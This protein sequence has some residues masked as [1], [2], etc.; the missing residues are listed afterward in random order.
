M[1]FPISK[2]AKIL[3]YLLF[4]LALSSGI[5]AYSRESEDTDTQLISNPLRIHY[6]GTVEGGN[7][8]PWDG[9]MRDSSGVATLNT[10][11]GVVI[12]PWLYTGL[13]VGIWT[14]YSHDGVG[15]GFPI[16]GDVRFTYPNQKWRPFL[17]L[18]V[19]A[20]AGDELSHLLLMPAAGIKFAI[21][22]TFGLYLSAGTLVSFAHGSVGLSL[23]LGFD[24]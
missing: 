1:K 6:M 22:D 3:K 16:Y 19:G 10:T 9:F 7:L 14:L 24:F 23:N 15:F 18:K 21:K 11:H 4:I 20:L 12:T 17:D 2:Q 8:F 5:Y 13:G